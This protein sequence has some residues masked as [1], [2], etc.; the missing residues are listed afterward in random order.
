MY[1]L[2]FGAP[3]EAQ[4]GWSCRRGQDHMRR[5]SNLMGRESAEPAQDVVRKNKQKMFS[6]EGRRRG[7]RG[8]MPI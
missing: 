2:Y 5:R 3:A 6:K 7:G 8:G 1:R 4:R